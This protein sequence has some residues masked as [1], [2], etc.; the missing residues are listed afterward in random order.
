MKELSEVNIRQETSRLVHLLQTSEDRDEWENISTELI[1]ML[2]AYWDEHPHSAMEMLE[3]TV[4]SLPIKLAQPL[5]CKV[6]SAWKNK[7][8]YDPDAG[9]NADHC[10][11]ISTYSIG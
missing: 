7:P 11:S 9:G 6:V 2:V 1:P 10:L 4:R 8:N 3:V 5:V